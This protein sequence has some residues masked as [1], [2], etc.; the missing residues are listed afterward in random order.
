MLLLVLPMAVNNT[1]DDTVTFD[2]DIADD[3]FDADDED[4][5]VVVEG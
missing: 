3:D 2:F 4:D 1:E 5:G